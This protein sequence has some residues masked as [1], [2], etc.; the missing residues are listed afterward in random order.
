[1]PRLKIKFL[2]GSVMMLVLFFCSAPIFWEDNKQLK[3]EMS[4]LEQQLTKTTSSSSMR[5]HSVVEKVSIPLLALTVQSCPF[6]I[7][8][9]YARVLLFLQTA[10]PPPS[11][12]DTK[13]LN[14]PAELQESG[15]IEPKEFFVFHNNIVWCNVFKSA[16]TRF[17]LD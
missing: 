7:V 12:I 4:P 10:E 3:T 6:Y 8:Y 9:I 13:L 5:K 16:S 11:R 1:M 17:V 2:G 15:D 14:C